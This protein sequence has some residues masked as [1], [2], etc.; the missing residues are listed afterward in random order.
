MKRL[1]VILLL[2]LPCLFSIAQ[3]APPTTFK[4]YS[5]GFSDPVSVE[6]TLQALVGPDG[7]VVIDEANQRALVVATEEEH[8]RIAEV[9]K[10]LNHPPKNVRIEV[11]FEGAGAAS[12]TRFGISGA[13]RV[14][15]KSGMS[16]TTIT[17]QPQIQ[18]SSLTHSANVMQTLLVA[19][20][21]TGMLRVGEEVPYLDWLMSYGLHAGYFQSELKWQKI[22][23]YLIVEPVVVG[24]GPM[25]RIRLTPELRGLVD[26]NPYHTKFAGVST[27][28]MVLDGQT[29]QVGGL[30]KDADFYS[31]FLVGVGR[32][33][34]T[35][36]MQIYLTPHIVGPRGF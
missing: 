25:I 13:G 33:G 3:E 35:E 28:V 9:M 10:Q 30:A 1:L 12:D 21:R 23:S 27:E 24:D 34:V 26:G 19:S 5:F 15:R 29:F 17:V 22:G 6:Q 32:S 16:S 11:R 18:S 7:N 20:G 14:T 36:S 4:T 2:T 8:A 31:R